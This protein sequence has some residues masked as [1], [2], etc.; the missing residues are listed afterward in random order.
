M[1]LEL[2]IIGMLIAMSLGLAAE[3]IPET[4]CWTYPD[5]LV[6]KEPNPVN[7]TVYIKN[8]SCYSYDIY[9]GN[10]WTP[11]ICVANATLKTTHVEVCYKYL[12]FVNGKPDISR[13]SD[14]YNCNEQVW[15]GNAQL[16]I[17]YN[18]L[19]VK[20]QLKQT[21]N[22]TR[23][24]TVNVNS[25]FVIYGT[26]NNNNGTKAIFVIKIQRVQN[27]WWYIIGGIIALIVIYGVYKWRRS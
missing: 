3:Y 4:G 8:I 23:F 17:P 1:K 19:P 13:Y 27:N 21:D 26:G 6:C 18:L 5:K 24:C 12:P 2:A 25:N 14:K 10:S 22:Y 20:C 15:F 7:A 16:R 11:P 9:S